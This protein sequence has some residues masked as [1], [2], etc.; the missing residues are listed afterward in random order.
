MDKLSSSV[1]EYGTCLLNMTMGQALLPHV[2][3]MLQALSL[4]P[5]KYSMFAFFIIN[6]RY[7]F[8]VKGETTLNL[9]IS[10]VWYVMSLWLFLDDTSHEYI[11]KYCQG[12]YMNSSINLFSFPDLKI[13][14]TELYFFGQNPALSCQQL[15]MKYCN[16]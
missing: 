8:K 3:C 9:I 13:N 7:I 6:F 5:H 4:I 15:V 14:L 16:G 1:C 12:W 11:Y 10:V 2:N